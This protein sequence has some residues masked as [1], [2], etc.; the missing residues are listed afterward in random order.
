[1]LPAH[2][3][4]ASRL[5][6]ERRPGDLSWGLEHAD[7]CAAG[8]Q[9]SLEGTRFD[10]ATI[11]VLR[12]TTSGTETSFEITLETVV[13]DAMNFGTNAGDPGRGTED[14]SLVAAKMKGSAEKQDFTW[15]FLANTP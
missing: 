9:Y 1:M 13:I 7:V 8:V 14:F 2:D 10:S 4:W 5:L 12:N 6:D 3:P 11:Y 15:D